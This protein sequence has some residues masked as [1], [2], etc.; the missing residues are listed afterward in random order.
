MSIVPT[1][2]DACQAGSGGSPP[3]CHEEPPERRTH[4]R[5]V[6]PGGRCQLFRQPFARWCQGLRY[7]E[8]GLLV[9]LLVEVDR[10][11]RGPVLVITKVA[12]VDRLGLG[13]GKC[14]L[15]R[16]MRRLEEI[17][18][19]AWR[20]GVGGL[21]G[22][23]VVLAYDEVVARGRPG[24]ASCTLRCA[25]VDD[26]ID[27]LGFDAWALLVNVA[28]EV[29]SVTRAIRGTARGMA[30]HLDVDRHL[31]RALVE[32]LSSA[33]E[34]EWTPRT[35]PGARLEVLGYARMVASSTSEDVGVVDVT[36]S[37]GVR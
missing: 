7:D 18:A 20:P 17:G 6:P 23:V 34:I 30:R 15:S 36:T 22:E 13:E 11:R 37:G 28:I 9:W 25:P 14:R 12:L 3:G 35:R 2:P 5:A 27:R 21:D 32:E 16:M 1:H 8:R 24:G 31:L 29:G 10:R 26:D 19:I 4:L 33:G